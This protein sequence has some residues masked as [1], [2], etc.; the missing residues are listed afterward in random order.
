MRKIFENIL[1]FINCKQASGKLKNDGNAMIETAV[2]LPLLVCIILFILESFRVNTSMSAMD[3]I[4]YQATLSFITH[5]STSDFKNIV[6]RYISPNIAKKNIKYRIVVYKSLNDLYNSIDHG[7]EEVANYTA[8]GS[9]D[10]S[11]G[12]FFDTNSN[13]KFDATTNY[14][15]AGNNPPAVAKGCAFVV[16]FVCDFQFSS[17]FMAKLYGTSNTIAKSSDNGVIDRDGK[18]LIWGRGTGVCL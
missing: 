3:S 16:T 14:I 8:A 9:P 12:G 6:E 10:T 5:K 1:S 11:I 2:G 4:A 18:F 15:Y 17:A 13:K 7:G